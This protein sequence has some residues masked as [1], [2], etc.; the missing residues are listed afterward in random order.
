MNTAVSI[1]DAAELAHLETKS[2][3][4][5]GLLHLAS[6]E[7]AEV[8]TSPRRGAVTIAPIDITQHKK[9]LKVS[10]VRSVLANCDGVWFLFCGSFD[11]EG[12]DLRVDAGKRSKLVLAGIGLEFLFELFELFDGFFFA[13]SDV[14][15]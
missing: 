2:G 7:E 15:L 3:V 12:V 6:L 8:A 10:N 5:K 1:H 14:G 9:Q 11:A 13:S 4:F